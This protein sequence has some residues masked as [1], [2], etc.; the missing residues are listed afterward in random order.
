MPVTVH[1]EV[2]WSVNRTDSGWLVTL[3]NP[4]GQGKPQHG[5]VPTDYRQNREVTIRAK[6][7]FKSARDRLLPDDALT[8]KPDSGDGA[9]VTLTVPAGSVRIIELN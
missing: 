6:L 7:P 9:S 2:E 1:G 3:L 5:I 4:A 8:V